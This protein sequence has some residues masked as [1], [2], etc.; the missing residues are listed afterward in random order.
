MFYYVK[1]VHSHSR[2][3]AGELMQLWRA[4]GLEGVDQNVWLRKLI[5]LTDSE[6]F[7]VVIEAT[8]GKKHMGD[9]AIDDISFTPQCR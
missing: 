5:E 1:N 7:R 2:N 6:Q 3:E 9:I 8:V 4:S